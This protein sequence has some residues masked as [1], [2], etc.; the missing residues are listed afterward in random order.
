MALSSPVSRSIALAVLAIGTAAAAVAAVDEVDEAFRSAG[1]FTLARTDA[2]AYSEPT[3]GLDYR[4][5]QRFMRGRH[6]F[7]QNWV[8]FPSI[9][10]RRAV[11][12]SSCARCWC[13]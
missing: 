2:E 9:G 10:G 8:Q 7:N 12:T 5:H 1:D 6:H 3:P 11:P 4:Q 13:A